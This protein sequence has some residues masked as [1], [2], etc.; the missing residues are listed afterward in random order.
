MMS[1]E[2]QRH[3]KSRSSA[4]QSTS[5]KFSARSAPADIPG[6]TFESACA[7]LRT[8]PRNA[9]QRLKV[10]T[11]T[12]ILA[13]TARDVLRLEQVGDSTWKDIV[14]LK[15]RITR[16]ANAPRE[17][18]EQIRQII[19]LWKERPATPA[20]LEQLPLF[21][22]RARNDVSPDQLHETYLPKLSLRRL[23]LPARASKLFERLRMVS[24]GYLLFTR[25]TALLEHRDFGKVTL[26]QVRE[27]IKAA[28]LEKGRLKGEG[29]DFT[30]LSG[31]TKSFVRSV[32]TN[33]RHAEMLLKQL[34]FTGGDVPAYTEIADTQVV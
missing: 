1:I 33:R 22:N 27:V 20:A 13:V 25:A 26:G 16:H 24:L 9:L 5:G 2:R 4:R 12:D 8:R 6:L 11:L 7:S 10:K 28:I 29:V 30:S 32:V 19:A 21:C 17:T 34:G 14:E 15:R 18:P 31:M 23:P 3:K